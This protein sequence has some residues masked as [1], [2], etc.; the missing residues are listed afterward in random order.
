MELEALQSIYADDFKKLNDEPHEFEIT[1]IPNTD[2]KNNHVSIALHVVYTPRY[3][4][5][6]P[7][8]T[9]KPLTGGITP[10]QIKEVTQKLDA[11]AKENLDVVMVLTLAQTAKEWLEG[12]NDAKLKAIQDQRDEEERQEKLK[13]IKTIDIEDV[14]QERVVIIGTPVTKENFLEWRTKFE[15]ETKKRKAGEGE[16]RLTGRQIFASDPAFIDDAVTLK[17]IA[18]LK[19]KNANYLEDD[20]DESTIVVEE[21][22]SKR[23]ALS[24]SQGEGDVAVDADL[25]VADE[26]EE[27]PEFSDEE[28]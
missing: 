4:Q 6:V 9:L 8:I 15:A 19:A 17:A 13:Q 3:P 12:L 7:T 28:D 2:G 1:L 11:E 21:D 14:K 18:A 22:P 10:E 24:S 20:A 26:A 5:E 23:L 27:L 25:F 16:L